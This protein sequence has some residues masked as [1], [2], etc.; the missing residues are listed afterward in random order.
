MSL[1]DKWLDYYAANRTWIKHLMEKDS[2]WYRKTEDDCKR[3]DARFIIGVVSAL[4]SSLRDMLPTFCKLNTNY[5]A[6]LEAIG[7]E[8]D[9]EKELEKRQQ[10]QPNY[11]SDEDYLNQIREQ[12]RQKNL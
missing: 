10:E 11:Q 8:F 12:A 6:L 3:P 7:L 1:K 5:D 4:D 2:S 9:P